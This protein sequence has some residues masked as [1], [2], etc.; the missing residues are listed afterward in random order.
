[1]KKKIYISILLGLMVAYSASAESYFMSKQVKGSFEEVVQK[2][3]NELKKVGFGVTVENRMDQVLKEK[4]DDVQMKPYLILG[5]CNPGYAHQVLQAEENIG[6]FLPCKVLVKKISDTTS[7]V[8]LINPSA[9]MKTIG[10]KNLD[11]VAEKVTK[12]FKKALS[13]I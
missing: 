3:K 9:V 2:T 1:M 11:K 13:N 5:I 7:E 4:L 10:N 12:Q 6:L 8:V